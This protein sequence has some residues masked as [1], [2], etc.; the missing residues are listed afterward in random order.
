ML[1][2][3]QIEELLGA[4]ANL[5][6]HQSKTI[7]SAMLHTPGSDFVDRG[8]ISIKNGSSVDGKY[9]ISPVFNEYVLLGG[10][11]GC[12]AVPNEQYHTFYSPQKI[13]EY[14][15]SRKRNQGIWDESV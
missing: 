2:T 3:Q 15:S 14:E 9:F 12:Y 8:M 7:P 13:E 5:L 10:K 1:N 11:V 6:T 4:N